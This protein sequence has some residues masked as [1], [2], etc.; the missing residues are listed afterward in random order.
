MEGRGESFLLFYFSRS[1]LLGI[2]L[3]PGYFFFTV[4]LAAVACFAAANKASNEKK[5]DPGGSGVI[6]SRD[7]SRNRES[8][9]TVT[10]KI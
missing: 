3:E 7:S 9:L 4:L 1:L 5:V 6:V 10:A 8:S 2:E